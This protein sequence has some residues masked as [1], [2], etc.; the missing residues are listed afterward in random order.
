MSVNFSTKNLSAVLLFVVEVQLFSAYRKVKSADIKEAKG[1]DIEADGV[2]TLGSQRVFEKSRLNVFNRHRESM[3]RTCRK[4]GVPF[5]GGYAIPDT[6]GDAAAQELDTIVAEAMAEKG[7]LLADYEKLL[8]DFCAANVQWEKQIRARAFTPQYIDERVKYAYHAMRV[9]APR[10]RGS[11]ASGLEGQVG[12]L[13][14]ELLKDIA[15]TAQDVQKESLAG[16]EKVTR[17]TLRPLK[18]ARDKLL[19]FVFLDPRVEAVAEMIDAVCGAV[20][21]D[22]PIAGAD[23]AM[24]WGITGM[25]MDPAKV[26]AVAEGY[27]PTSAADFLASLRPAPLAVPPAQQPTS[28]DDG[29]TAVA[30]MEAGPAD[31]EVST[32]PAD[33]YGGLLLNGGAGAV[34]EPLLPAD[35]EEENALAGLFGV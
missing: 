16:R 34:G 33:S 12:G 1:V 10:D 22:G 15:A 11:M 5:L 9:S 6:H 14:G 20:P 21:P 30:V 4:Y 29:Q 17:K 32:D 35:V 25:L 27:Q 18:A 7:R 23:L 3:H 24:L 19:G 13:L 8:E 2:L 28:A 31:I 26:M